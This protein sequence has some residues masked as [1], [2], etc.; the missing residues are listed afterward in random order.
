MKNV[1]ILLAALLSAGSGWAGDLPVEARIEQAMPGRELEAA[2]AFDRLADQYPESDLVP[3]ALLQAGL[4]FG[5]ANAWDEATARF[6]TLAGLPTYHEYS[7]TARRLLADAH[8]RVADRCIRDRRQGIRP[9]GDVPVR[10]LHHPVQ[11][12]R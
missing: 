11:S 12:V 3:E 9:A 8:T 4:M 2:R 7:A 1:L 6:D 10:H 5:R